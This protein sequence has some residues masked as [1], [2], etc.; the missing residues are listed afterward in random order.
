MKRTG[1]VFTRVA[2][3]AMAVFAVLGSLFVAGYAFED[4]GG[5]QAVGL[6][7]SW[8]VPM[9]VLAFVA[10][11][12]PSVGVWVMAGALVLVAGGLVWAV[13]EASAWHDFV[14]DVGPV[15]GIATFALGLPLAVLGLRRPTTAG[16]MIVA[17]SVMAYVAFLASV[18]DEPGRGLGAS[19]STSSTAMVAPFLV[20]GLLF[21]V[22]G[23]LEHYGGTGARP[24]A[25]PP[26]T[27]TPVGPAPAPTG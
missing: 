16:L 2:F 19:L 18:E 3:W 6:V 4:P 21:L 17:V 20:I 11:R 13:V 8:A 27:R 23:L 10:W 12:W 9:L 25:G 5:W 14:N 1:H 24:V 26:S 15:P 7:A 22:G